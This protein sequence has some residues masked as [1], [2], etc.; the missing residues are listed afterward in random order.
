[1]RDICLT[2][3]SKWMICVGPYLQED[4]R[5]PQKYGIIGELVLCECLLQLDLTDVSVWDL[6][7]HKVAKYA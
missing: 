4:K 1:M 6:E 5:L 2:S 7:S 3:D